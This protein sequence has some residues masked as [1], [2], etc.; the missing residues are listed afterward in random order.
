MKDEGRIEASKKSLKNF[1]RSKYFLISALMIVGGGL[2]GFLFYFFVGCKTGTCAITSNPY[3]SII[4]G[5]LLG[6]LLIGKPSEKTGN[7][8]I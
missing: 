1:L 7:D 2:A 5:S 8:T 4:M 6:F 3:N